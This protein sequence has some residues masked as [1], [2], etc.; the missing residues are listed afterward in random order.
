MQIQCTHLER[1]SI[2]LRPAILL[3]AM[4]ATG[5]LVAGEMSLHGHY[6]F[7]G[8]VHVA[9]RGENGTWVIG[10]R[11]IGS[12]RNTTFLNRETPL[13]VGACV[14]VEM[15]NRDALTIETVRTEQC[16]KTVH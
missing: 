14:R 12:T 13:S 1:F 16:F 3:I 10:D 7:F 2:S 8:I 9:P 11:T 15:W 5:N 6:Q 4:L